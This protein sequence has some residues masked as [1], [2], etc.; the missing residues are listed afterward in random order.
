M[1]NKER[2]CKLNSKDFYEQTKSILNNPL[3][4]Y[5]DYERYF[6]SEDEDISHFI[7]NLSKCRLNP[8]EAEVQAAQNAGIKTDAQWYAQKAEKEYLLLDLCQVYG[9]E[10]ATLGYI[11]DN[12]MQIIKVPRAN[13]V[14]EKKTLSDEE[15]SESMNTDENYPIEPIFIDVNAEGKPYVAYRDCGRKAK[16]ID[17]INRLRLQSVNAYLRAKAGQTSSQED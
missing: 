4:Q 1:T 16:A 6:D 10:Y 14:L 12:K 7:K 3:A 13:V 17:E 2:L 8:S 15:R 11:E 5:I 9:S